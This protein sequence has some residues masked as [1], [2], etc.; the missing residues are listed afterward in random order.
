VCIDRITEKTQSGGT[1]LQYG[2]SPTFIVTQ[3]ED[4]ITGPWIY[5]VKTTESG[6][7]WW[8]KKTNEAGESIKASFLPNTVIDFNTGLLYTNN[9]RL[10]NLIARYKTIITEDNINSYTTDYT[11]TDKDNASTKYKRFLFEKTGNWIEIQGFSSTCFIVMP[12]EQGNKY[13][14][15]NGKNQTSANTGAEYMRQF[16][17]Q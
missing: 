13:C 14:T 15:T 2:V 8:G 7:F 4:G 16:L 10:K 5:E 17:G 6:G 12:Q 11:V 3:D 9:I 1:V